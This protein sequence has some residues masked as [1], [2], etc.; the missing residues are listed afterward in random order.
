MNAIA[1][2]IATIIEKENITQLTFPK[3]DVLHSEIKQDERQRRVIRAMKLGNNKKHKVK[4][5]FEDVESLKKVETT[6]WGVTEK[7]IILK[8]GTLIPI[9]RIHEIKFY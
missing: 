4:I 9:H 1:T 7:N 2:R 3:S 6:I 5:I 8:Q